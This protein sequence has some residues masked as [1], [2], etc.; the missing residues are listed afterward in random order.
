[1]SQTQTFETSAGPVKITPIYHA[2]ALIEAGGK[3]IY[4]DPAGKLKFPNVSP[5]PV[6]YSG[7]RPADLI[8]ITDIHGDHMDAAADA[9]L[10][11]AGTQIIA[12]PSVV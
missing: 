9:T 8:L 2:S 3:L 1:M 4:V 11:K 7:Y 6:D 5:G 12:P 10:S